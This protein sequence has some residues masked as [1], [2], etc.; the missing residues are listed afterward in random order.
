MG[1]GVVVA[2]VSNRIYFRSTL[3]ALELLAVLI[4]KERIAR[5]MPAQELAGRAGISR[6]LLQRIEKADPR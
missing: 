4:R 1:Q 6:G 2:K 3:E 5:K